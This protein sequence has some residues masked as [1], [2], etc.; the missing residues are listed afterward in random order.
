MTKLVDL[1]TNAPQAS[2]F[3]KQF[4]D[5]PLIVFVVLGDGSD[6]DDL[7][8]KAVSLAGNDTDPTRVVRARVPQQIQAQVAA[9]PGSKP[10]MA[11]PDRGF[12]LSLE[13]RITDIIAA[14]ELKPDLVRVQLCWDSAEAGG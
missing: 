8:Q 10:D 14:G 3:F 6:A 13:H 2:A 4:L 7:A 9:L 1:G 12:A 5:S 11:A